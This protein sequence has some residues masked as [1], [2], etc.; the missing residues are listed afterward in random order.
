MDDLASAMFDDE[1]TIQNS[2]GEC[3]DGEETHGCD[4]FLV[5]AQEGSPEFACLVGRRQAAEIA[6]EGRFGDVQSEFQK[7]TRYSRSSPGGI[8]LH[9]PADESS[10][11]GIDYWS[12]KALWP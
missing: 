5:F 6:R 3:S 12:A 1:E 7:L 8:L 4:D 10:K 2:K 11:L 9:H